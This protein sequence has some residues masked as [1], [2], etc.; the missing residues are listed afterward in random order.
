MLK[1]L[2]GTLFLFFVVMILPLVLDIMGNG[3]VTGRGLSGS[4][5]A[6]AVVTCWHL[7]RINRQMRKDARE[8]RLRERAEAQRM[9]GW[10][11]DQNLL[12]GGLE[13]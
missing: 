7:Y 8:E 12:R 3:T 4:V 5:A 6:A 2:L 13:R 1:A 10:Y 11:Q 9:I